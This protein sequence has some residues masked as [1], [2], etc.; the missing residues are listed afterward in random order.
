M[1]TPTGTVHFISA[2]DAHELTKALEAE[3]YT[4][5]LRQDP[6]ADLRRQWLLE[7]APFDD[8]V[9]ALVDVYGG[10]LPEEL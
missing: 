5:E 4:A 3:G 9:V 10:W 6:G 8:G 2:D 1:E 7:V